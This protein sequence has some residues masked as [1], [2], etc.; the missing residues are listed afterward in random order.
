MEELSSVKDIGN[1]IAGN[2]VDFFKD[3]DNL[4][5]ID[6]LLESG[7]KIEEKS[8]KMIKNA[9]FEGKTF[10]FDRDFGRF[11]SLAGTRTY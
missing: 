8:K 2:I 9:N 6:K 4:K 7:V 10:V 5:E 3:E 11:Y 1:V